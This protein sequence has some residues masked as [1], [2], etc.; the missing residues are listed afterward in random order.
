[1]SIAT[2]P[3]IDLYYE[4][5]GDGQPLVFIHG[6]GGSHLSWWQQVP[7]FAE[8]YRVLVYDQ[9]G[10]GGSRPGERYEPSDAVALTDDLL[11]LL[12]HL[13]IS[14]PVVVVGHSLGSFPALD[15][16]QSHPERVARLVLLCGYGAL[17]DERLRGFAEKRAGMFA[18][19]APAVPSI[20]R[21]PDESAAFGATD[22]SAFLFGPG[23][24][25]D[26]AK[27]FLFSSIR[28][29]SNGPSLQQLSGVFAS[30]R[31]IDSA[32]A[33]E[34]A[35][36]VLVLAG[37]EDPMFPPAEMEIVASMFGKGRFGSLPGAGHAA[38]FERPAEFNAAVD[39]FLATPATHAN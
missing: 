23:L 20:T 10:F 19:A 11:H 29:V 35:T 27:R 36:E 9:R 17:T 8:R 4:S 5:H 21:S 7:A 6:A 30:A 37:E 22:A 39:R 33:G 2:L 34:L 25:D 13:G 12:D 31:R 1:M 3:G 28:Q 16:A 24:R 15:F 14:E 26:A 38:Y 18:A 32:M